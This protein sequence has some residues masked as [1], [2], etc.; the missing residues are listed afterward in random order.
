MRCLYPYCLYSSDH[1]HRARL[2]IYLCDKAVLCS[3]GDINIL[4]HSFTLL[5]FSKKWLRHSRIP[6]LLALGNIYMYVS[7][8]ATHGWFVRSRIFRPAWYFF[9]PCTWCRILLFHFVYY[10]VHSQ[11]KVMSNLVKI[12]HV[13]LNIFSVFCYILLLFN[14]FVNLSSSFAKIK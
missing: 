10:T 7:L 14:L 12:Y 1:I 6:L 3:G 13:S 4:L 5:G 9:L 11:V 2:V 8:V